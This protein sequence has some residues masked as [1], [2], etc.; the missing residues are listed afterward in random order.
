MNV[1]EDSFGG[2]KPF[3]EAL[4]RLGL[5]SKTCPVC[6]GDVTVHHYPS[7]THP[8]LRCPEHGE[9]SAWT[10]S[11][12][13]KNQI[14]DIPRFIF[15]LKMFMLGAGTSVIAGMIGMQRATVARYV[16]LIRTA[17]CKRI[18]EEKAAGRMKMGG[19]GKHVEIDETWPAQNKNGVGHVPGKMDLWVVGLLEVDG[20][21]VE[22]QNPEVLA[23]MKADEERR[24]ADE[25]AR[26]EK[27]PKPMTASARL[28]KKQP[29]KTPK[30][31][32]VRQTA[33]VQVADDA[34]APENE[35][36]TQGLTVVVSQ[37][38]AEEA[39][40]K[41]LD[42][43]Y[44]DHLGRRCLSQAKKNKPRKALFFVVDHRDKETLE[45]IIKEN[46]LEGTTVYTDQWE[47]YNGLAALGYT[48]K[49][50]CHKFRFARKEF[51]GDMVE[52][53]TTNHIERL[54]VEVK[55]SI[56]YMPREDVADFINITSYRERFLFS[57]D[58][59]ENLKQLMK[60]L[61]K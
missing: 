49:T 23:R 38:F 34:G 37:R 12:F 13:D 14:P 43:A 21:A 61:A 36:P 40:Q 51:S 31:A 2:K 59:A 11:F 55:R 7:K 35:Q 54:W 41:R 22:V 57:E 56:K 42:Q 25:K 19:R 44:L 16:K 27:K 60:E 50:V 32:F 28:K 29:R 33:T 9:R 20:D 8:I 15:V 1:N 17:M 45:A 24:N 58:V 30:S 18:N 3:Y 6:N 26:R 4:Q 53:V 39:K 47:G 52:R 5:L 10:K 48:H 46:V